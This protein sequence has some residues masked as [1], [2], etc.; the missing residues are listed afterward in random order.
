MTL[1]VLNSFQTGAPPN[2]CTTTIPN[3]SKAK[4]QLI[5]S[6]YRISVTNLDTPDGLIR[7]RLYSK[8]PSDYFTGFILWANMTST[9]IGH[10]SWGVFEILNNDSSILD[11]G[12]QQV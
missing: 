3:H 5:P 11:C 12:T 7:V 10:K 2:S 6:W 4:H 8:S 9:N 1:P